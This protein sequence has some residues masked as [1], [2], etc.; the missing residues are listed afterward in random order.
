MQ[1]PQAI[2]DY[3]IQSDAVR[4]RFARLKT[5]DVILEVRHLGKR[6]K[7]PQ[8]ECVALNDIS[9]KTHRREFVCVIGPSGCGKSTLIRILAGLE[10]QSSGDVLLDGKPVQGP[11]ADR[12]M[13]FQGY[14]LFPWLTVKKNVMF[15]LRMNGSSSGE[16]EREAMQWLD[17]V[18][19]TRFANVYPHQLSGG[20]KQRV[21][22]ARAL[23]NRP[24][25][26]LMDE[27]F[28]ALDAQ[29]RA[30]M[31]AHLLDI[32]RNIDITILFITHDLDEAIFLADRILVLKANPGEVQ[33]LIEVPVPRPRDYAQV[34]SP[35]FVATKARLEALIH[36]KEA[37]EAPDEDGGRPHMIRM[38][39]VTDNVE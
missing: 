37:A 38:T 27:P 34:N 35:E 30:K 9:F 3:L 2:P 13:V 17:L 36:P 22:I 28:G 29:T 21:A 39:D 12:G 7:S 16:A 4:A 10:S 32:W 15:G 11:G 33:E 19:L 5:R 24:R 23:A 6:F 25:I 8:G 26:L 14:T 20:M 31:Q 1:N 18:G